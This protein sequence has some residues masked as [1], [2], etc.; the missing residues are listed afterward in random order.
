[1]ERKGKVGKV[2]DWLSVSH[3]SG[4]PVSSGCQL[5][6]RF[7]GPQRTAA[8]FSVSSNG[9]SAQ[10]EPFDTNTVKAEFAQMGFTSGSVT[11]SLDLVVN[12]SWILHNAR[13][14]EREELLGLKQSSS[15]TSSCLPWAA[16]TDFYKQQTCPG[17]L[18]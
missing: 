7:R 13:G 2:Q 12:P 11:F 8:A 14:G 5:Q 1:M 18:G 17:D 3:S 9:H 10:V 16:N 4:K 6:L 15:F